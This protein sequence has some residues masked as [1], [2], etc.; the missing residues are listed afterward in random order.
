MVMTQCKVHQEVQILISSNNKMNNNN[1]NKMASLLSHHRHSVNS[2]P[3]FNNNCNKKIN[4][5]NHKNKSYLHKNKSVTLIFGIEE[6][7][8]VGTNF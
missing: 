6:S 1:S 7:T 2:N 3:I 4:L 8:K 5:F